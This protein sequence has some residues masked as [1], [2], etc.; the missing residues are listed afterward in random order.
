MYFGKV[1]KTKPKAFE[2]YL[3]KKVGTFYIIFS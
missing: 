2:L 3:Q 1:K